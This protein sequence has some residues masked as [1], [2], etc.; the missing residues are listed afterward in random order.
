ML[1]FEVN[2]WNLEENMPVSSYGKGISLKLILK[3]C[4][5]YMLQHLSGI[6]LHYCNAFTKTLAITKPNKRSLTDFGSALTPNFPTKIHRLVLP[7]RIVIFHAK[8]LIAQHD[9][10]DPW[11]TIS[12]ASFKCRQSTCEGPNRAQTNLLN[13]QESNPTRHV[14]E[15][16]GK[17]VKDFGAKSRWWPFILDIR[18]ALE[19]KTFFWMFGR[20]QRFPI[21]EKGVLIFW[22]FSIDIHPVQD[23]EDKYSI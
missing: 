23:L 11:S 6:L 9:P 4:L 19:S 16:D 2:E 17:L 21:W 8:R 3:N 13:F 1:P 20:C 7:H 12:D 14:G 10:Q 5:S 15:D 18:K 22:L